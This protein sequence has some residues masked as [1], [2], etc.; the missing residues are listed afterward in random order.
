MEIPIWCASSIHVLMNLSFIAFHNELNKLN[1]KVD[2][3]YHM[4]L[5]LLISHFGMK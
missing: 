3:I 5:K 2:C 4:S 1:R